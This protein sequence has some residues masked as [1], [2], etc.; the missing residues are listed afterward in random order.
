[1]PSASTKLRVT[2]WMMILVHHGRVV[3]GKTG[4]QGV[5]LHLME[6]AR[7][8]EWMDGFFKFQGHLTSSLDIM[9]LLARHKMKI[10]KSM[11]IDRWKAFCKSKKKMSKERFTGPHTKNA[12]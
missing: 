12:F 1:M 6:K 3:N 9:T 5:H 2:L 4:T 8:D 10:G 11:G 7:R